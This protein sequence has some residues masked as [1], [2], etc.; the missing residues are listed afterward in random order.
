MAPCAC[1]K[2][3]LSILTK[4]LRFVRKEC[5]EVKNIFLILI[6][7]FTR[8]LVSHFLQL[9]KY[10]RKLYYKRSIYYIGQLAAIFYEFYNIAVKC[11]S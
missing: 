7:N 9:L 10:K 11:L 5:L 8:V 6:Y 3:K 4:I 1:A 2:K